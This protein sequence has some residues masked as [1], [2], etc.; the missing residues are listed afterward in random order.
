MGV[1]PRLPRRARARSSCSTMYYLMKF[2]YG[3]KPKDEDI[4]A[5]KISRKA[6]I[7]FF[8]FH[9]LF[10]LLNLYYFIYFFFMHQ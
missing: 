10:L 5:Q 1:Q 7:A 4:G 9:F 8:A 2:P 6:F 3:G